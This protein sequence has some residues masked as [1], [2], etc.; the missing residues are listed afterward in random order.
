MADV[1][2]TGLVFSSDTTSEFDGEYWTVITSIVE[3]RKPKDGDW[4]EKKLSAKG[5]STSFQEAYRTSFMSVNEQFDD[6]MKY[7]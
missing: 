4:E 6:V 1:K 7:E 5:I 2:Y 3:K